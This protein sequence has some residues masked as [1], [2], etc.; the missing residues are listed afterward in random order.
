SL[1]KTTIMPLTFL[2]DRRCDICLTTLLTGEMLEFCCNCRKCILPSLP[3]Y[4]ME[5]NDII[6][7]RNVSTLSRK[8]NMLF[9]FTANGV[10]ER[11]VAAHNYKVPSEWV[12]IVQQILIKVNSYTCSLRTLR[13]NSSAT[14]SLE[15]RENMSNGEVTAI[16]HAD[17]IINVQPRSILIRRDT[18]IAPKFVNILSA[19]YEPL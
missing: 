6:N 2:W 4:P 12:S 13:D 14:A 3:P 8:L 7:N 15:L 19:Q 16:I 10:Q 1:N 11:Y 9:S 18:D 17:N 5:I